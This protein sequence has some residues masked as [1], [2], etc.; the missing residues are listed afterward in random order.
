M[1]HEVGTPFG[2]FVAFSSL[3]FLGES[4]TPSGSNTVCS[5]EDPQ[6]QRTIKKCLPDKYK[7]GEVK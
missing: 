1:A 7:S 2:W 5:D 6:F 3:L 4:Q